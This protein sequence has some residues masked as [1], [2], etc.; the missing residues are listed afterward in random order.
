M[1]PEGL[2]TGRA[3]ASVADGRQWAC[4]QRG[5]GESR[6][7]GSPRQARR[8]GVLRPQVGCDY[9]RRDLGPCRD[10]VLL[11]LSRPR[12]E[13]RIMR[14]T[15]LLGYGNTA[16]IGDNE[17]PRQRRTG[18]PGRRPQRHRH[19]RRCELFVCVVGRRHR[20][21]LGRKRRLASRGLFPSVG[22]SEAPERPPG[23][24]RE[25]GVRAP[26]GSR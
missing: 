11:A 21:L 26:V 13:V 14:W 17:T 24:R 23:V 18:R 9:W 12:Q 3:N 15:G 22:W 25:C 6:P 20:P 8:I 19:H 7:N 2:S 4:R 5:L 16:N 10:D 1:V